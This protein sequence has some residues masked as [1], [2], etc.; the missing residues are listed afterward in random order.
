[1]ATTT[2]KLEKELSKNTDNNINSNDLYRNLLGVEGY[3]TNIKQAGNKLIVKHFPTGIKSNYSKSDNNTSSEDQKSKE[4]SYNNS[5]DEEK[6]VANIERA[7]NKRRKKIKGLLKCNIEELPNLITLTLGYQNYSS[8]IKNKIESGLIAEDEFTSKELKELEN[9][10]SI[11]RSSKL[12]KKNSVLR[13]KVRNTLMEVHSTNYKRI[14]KQN[15]NKSNRKIR[16]TFCQSMD[17]TVTKKDPTSIDDFNSMFKQFSEQITK[18]MEEKFKY[19]G[20]I[21]FQENGKIH[22]HMIC[23]IPKRF[24]KIRLNNLWHNGNIDIQNITN[25]KSKRRNDLQEAADFLGSYFTKENLDNAKC[26]KNNL[27][28]KNLYRT[29]KNL[30]RPIEIT[31]EKEKKIFINAIEKSNIELISYYKVNTNVEINWD[32]F[33]FENGKYIHTKTA[34]TQSKWFIK[35]SIKN[36]ISKE[37]KSNPYAKPCYIRIYK[38]S[39]KVYDIISKLRQKSGKALLQK[40]KQKNLDEIPDS[41]IKKYYDKYCKLLTKALNEI[42]IGE[43]DYNKFNNFQNKKIS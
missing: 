27:K 31:K 29:S 4:N 7:N 3:Y 24:T 42:K 17:N 32:D 10:Y 35:Q 22:F 25:P 36:P 1:M 33:K 21:E 14:K 30:N 12:K 26:K 23:N 38:L 37:E 18:E 19:I 39:K 34:L 20:V 28:N 6:R 40:A 5:S 8:L 43:K 9:Y 13:L 15:Q 16:D 2:N 41:M 11:T